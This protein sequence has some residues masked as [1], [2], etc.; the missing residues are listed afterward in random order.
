MNQ[1]SRRAFSPWPRVLV[2]TRPDGR[3]NLTVVNRI[4]L[5]GDSLVVIAE[6]DVNAENPAEV[7]RCIKWLSRFARPPVIR[8]AIR[9]GR[10][11]QIVRE[12][13]A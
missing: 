10:T 2:E 7:E 4:G 5:M 12:M 13:A 8:A 9:D 3:I 6:D 11:R 1:N